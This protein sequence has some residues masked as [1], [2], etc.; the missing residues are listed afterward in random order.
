M[1]FALFIQGQKIQAQRK[2]AETQRAQSFLCGFSLRSSRLCVSALGG[3]FY[4]RTVY[5]RT[6][7]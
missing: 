6:V 3:M 2:G 4:Q 7:A 1:A 5:E